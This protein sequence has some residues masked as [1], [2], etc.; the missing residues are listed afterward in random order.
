MFSPARLYLSCTDRD[1]DFFLS[2][3]NYF[4]DQ[5][6]GIKEQF[7]ATDEPLKTDYQFSDF[8]EFELSGN[9]GTRPKDKVKIWNQKGSPACTVYSATHIYN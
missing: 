7:F 6:I 5:M 1:I 9:I 2:F 4:V 8:E 3:F